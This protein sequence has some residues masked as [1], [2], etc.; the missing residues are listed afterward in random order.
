MIEF[1]E[2]PRLTRFDDVLLVVRELRKLGISGR[3]VYERITEIGPV[4]LDML[5]AVLRAEGRA[6]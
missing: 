5:N 1:A 2:R 4:D 6:S 3:T